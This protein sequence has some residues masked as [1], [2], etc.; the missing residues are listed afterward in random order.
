MNP[1]FHRAMPVQ[2]FGRLLQK[3]FKNIEEQGH[4]VAALDFFQRLTLD[5]LGHAVFGFDFGALNDR[6]AVWTVT[7][8]SIRLNLRNPLAFAFPSMDWLLKYVIPGRLQM[9]ASV[10]KLN[11]LMRDMIKEKRIKL[12]ETQAQ[13]DTPENEKDLLTLMLEAEQRGEGTTN[14]EELRVSK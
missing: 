4:Q 9:A 7:Y 1:A 5:A 11:G 14:D 13:D 6:E 2:M 8:E 12:L 10:D 3:G